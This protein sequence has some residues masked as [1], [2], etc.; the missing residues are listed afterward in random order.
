MKN[1]LL[2]LTFLLAA[3]AL[4][5]S[6]LAQGTAFTYQGRLSDGT[7]VAT[8]L[9][10]LRFAICD[11]AAGGTTLAPLATNGVP[12]TNGLFTVLL[13][14]GNDIFNGA[15]RWLQIGVRTNGS[16]AEYITLS[17]RQPI[18]PT[19]YAIHAAN[20]A[21]LDGQS[22]N[23]YVAKTGDAMTGPLNLP[24]D[25][26]VVGGNQLVLSAGNVGIG[27]TVPT[28]PLHVDG[29][30]VR[31]VKNNHP[32]VFNADAGGNATRAEMASDLAL[33]FAPGNAEKLRIDSIGNVGIGTENP[34]EKLDILSG[35]LVLGATHDLDGLNNY[36]SL[37]FRVPDVEGQF[38]SLRSSRSGT[39]GSAGNRY[40]LCLDLLND[41]TSDFS[42]CRQ[43]VG[44]I[45]G[46]RAS[47]Q[48]FI[49]GSLGIGTASPSDIL[50]IVQPG[51]TGVRWERNGYDTYTIGNI[52]PG[53][54]VYN[55]TDSRY[56]LV[57]D[58]T[59]RT[60][61]GTTSPSAKLDIG[62]TEP[63]SSLL[64]LSYNEAPDREEGVRG[65]VRF[66]DVSNEDFEIAM[67]PGRLRFREY[68]NTRE[69]LTLSNDGG[70]GIGTA[71][72]S[73]RLHVI[74]NQAYIQGTSDLAALDVNQGGTGPAALFRGGNVGIGTTSPQAPLDVVGTIKSTALQVNG[75][76]TTGVLTITGGADVA[77]PFAMSEP[78]LPKG[79]VVIIDEAQPGRLKLSAHPYDTRVAGIISGAGGVNSGLTLS[80]QGV[81]EG[82]QNVALSGRVYALADA[83]ESPIKPGDLLTTSETPGH[84]MKATDRERAYGTVIGKAM[85]GLT[86]GCGLVLV[87]VSLQ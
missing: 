87:L 40:S 27:T 67:S 22:A 37:R 55:V 69:I 59:G 77:E 50:H 84:C 52:G 53:F 25:G 6:A 70:V 28:S 75:A 32:L 3:L 42:V 29:A 66:G 64:A 5:A 1:Q 26:L 65:M 24:A 71:N 72:P 63:T 79:A 45:F 85:S 38:I 86:E 11:S 49:S 68:H 14:F 57:F 82:G 47:G 41:D 19:P 13:D 18:T 21:L 31:F 76:T 8:G 33:A 10:D 39:F 48:T 74:G 2:K 7:S 54:S 80:Q 51:G 58:G 15:P 56:D 83:T 62:G 34:T 44:P 35:N 30:D 16:A 81:L 17:P 4:P 9:F 78:D 43:V 23:D 46:V 20:A 73:V 61:I 36:G 60:G 12:V